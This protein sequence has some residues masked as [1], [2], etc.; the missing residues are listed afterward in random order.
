MKRQKNI[1]SNNFVKGLSGFH[2]VSF[3]RDVLSELVRFDDHTSDMRIAENSYLT[4]RY[5]HT[6]C[7]VK[8]IIKTMAL[9]T[10]TSYMT[11]ILTSSEQK[12]LDELPYLMLRCVK[13]Y[14]NLK[15][16]L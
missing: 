12:Y 9:W 5:V 8:K 13:V 10:A 14:W 11:K 16:Q 2:N 15:I 7:D 6:I 1:I 4:D 3:I